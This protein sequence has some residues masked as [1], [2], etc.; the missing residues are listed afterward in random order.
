VTRQAD[1]RG[2][3][4]VGPHGTRPAWSAAVE[5]KTG[6]NPLLAEQGA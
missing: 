3:D 4:L 5:V 2:Q 1:Q 6:E